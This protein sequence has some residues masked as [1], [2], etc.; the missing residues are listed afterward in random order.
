MALRTVQERAV[1]R[2]DKIK[3]INGGEDRQE[4]FEL[5]AGDQDQPAP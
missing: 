4:L 2:D 3:Q 1:F 5:S